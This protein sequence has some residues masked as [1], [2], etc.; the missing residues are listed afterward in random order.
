MRILANT[1]QNFRV[2]A[3]SRLKCPE[4]RSKRNEQ[5]DKYRTSH[6]LGLDM[7]FIQKVVCFL[8]PG[9]GEGIENTHTPSWIKTMSIPK[10]WEIFLSHVTTPFLSLHNFYVAF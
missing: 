4:T 6:G 1:T 2:R 7:I 9:I 8:S 5:I 3:F 10:P